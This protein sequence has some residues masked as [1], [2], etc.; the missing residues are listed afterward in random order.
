MSSAMPGHGVSQIA[1]G[2]PA[3]RTMSTSISSSMLPDFEVRVP[4]GAGSGLV[5]RVVHVHQVDAS[6]RL[7]D[8]FDDAVEFLSRSVR[9]ASVEAEA[10]IEFT[11]E[12]PEL[13]QDVDVSRHSVVPAG[14]V[15][16]EDGNRRVD[17]LERLPPPV[18][19]L[20]DP[21]LGSD[22]RERSPPRLR[23]PR[24]VRVCS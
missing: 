18:E 24:L 6:G 7:E 8:P 17:L 21:V 12:F 19:A 9:V 16:D 20:L 22:P 14:R 10:D 11:N 23:P 3:A 15:L 1:A 13:G 2:A 5:A 4:V